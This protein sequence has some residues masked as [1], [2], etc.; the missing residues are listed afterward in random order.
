MT[1][2]IPTPAH[3]RT[4]DRLVWQICD[5]QPWT[6]IGDVWFDALRLLEQTRSRVRRL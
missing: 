3:L 1:T 5:L 4:V 2:T 6:T